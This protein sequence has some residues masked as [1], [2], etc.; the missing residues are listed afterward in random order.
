MHASYN[1]DKCA[2]KRTQI[3]SFPTK[4]RTKKF[5]MCLLFTIS[6]KLLQQNILETML[7]DTPECPKLHHLK[8]S[9]RWNMSPNPLE[10]CSK[11]RRPSNSL[12]YDTQMTCL[13]M[14]LRPCNRV[15][16]ALDISVQAMRLSLLFLLTMY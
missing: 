15:L 6:L 11:T 1:L 3:S 14:E 2:M 7:E 4:F 9:F 12:K 13:N 16:Y 10:M 5:K 8:N